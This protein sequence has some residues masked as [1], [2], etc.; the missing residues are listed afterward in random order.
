MSDGKGTGGVAEPP[1]GPDSAETESAA[2]TPTPPSP[3][4]EGGKKGKPKPTTAEGR[5]VI[6]KHQRTL[7]DAPGVYRMLDAKGTVLYVGKAKS[8][9]KRVVSYTRLSGPDARIRRMVAATVT[10]EFTQTHT[11]VEALLLES[12]LI[13]KLKP[14]FNI[15]L[16]DDKSFPYILITGDTEWPQI[17]KHRGARKKKGQYF[18]PFASAGAVNATIN[19][20]QRA[21]PLRNC[22]DQVF[23][24]RTRPC[25]MY[26]IKR[27]TAPCVGR[28]DRD[29]YNKVVDQ[30][31]EFLRGR[32]HDIQGS[33]SKLMEE[34]SGALDYET[35]MIWRDRIRA[36]SAIQS[37]QGINLPHLGDFD[38]IAVYAQSGQ[39][40][41]QVFFFRSGQNYGNRPYY[42][43][44]ADEASESE[45]LTA[46][47]GQFYASA[48]PPPEVLLSAEVEN[49]P[50]LSEA[51][52]L[53][54]DR[55]VTLSVPARGIK[56]T[57]VANARSN[58]KAALERH[59]AES[60]TQ[61]KLLEAVAKTF[62]LESTPQRIEV[63]DNSHIMG[64]HAVG[65]MIVA[66]P[67]GFVKNQYRKFN[68][69]SE[70]LSPGDDF[71]MMR[72]VLSRR[73]WRLLKEQEEA[74]EVEPAEVTYAEAAE[75][76]ADYTVANDNE[77][78]E[79]ERAVDSGRAGWPDLVLIDGGQG[80]LTAACQV[81]ADLGV[82]GVA[83]VGIAKGPDRNAGIE[84]FFV[85][86][87]EPFRL[88]PGD[89][90]LYFLER[91]RD[92]AH[93]FVIEA[94]RAKRSKRIGMSPL[95]D[96]E[97]IG[98]SRKRALLNRFGSAK[99]VSGAALADLE[100][101]EGISSELADT[102][103]R[104]FHPEG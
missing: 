39:T 9:K 103:W 50:L 28:I 27:C 83:L 4:R 98:P 54:A 55:K 25:L 42:P 79:A 44:H 29:G 53:R 45:I 90:V 52:A 59:V 86:G 71:G 95:D 32:S 88:S 81:F 67:E 8:L 19:A 35:A 96:I 51:L 63:Y 12:N 15:L 85:P 104:H 6:L 69:K 36:L 48:T 24:S 89:P 14:R 56:K 84:R 37:K 57:L 38:V 74:A 77:R 65:A 70:E 99:A 20:L 78:V 101:V 91:L 30:A 64:A 49:A 82:T 31:A 22:S 73:F 10:M 26:Q 68:I 23:K 94:H 7:P 47:L 3:A 1:L 80:Q 93:R 87:K 16:R 76:P 66:G 92:E 72:E 100:S 18:G 62:E 43:A 61:R 75:P 40:C 102:I 11:E 34:A 46:F 2:P 97:G 21:F 41:V 33:M 13:K 5:A 58:A 60:A 17:T